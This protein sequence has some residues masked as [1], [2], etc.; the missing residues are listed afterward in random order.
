M[1]TSVNMRPQSIDEM[2]G[3]ESIREKAR[4]AVGAALNRDEPLGHCLLTSAGGGLGKTSFAQ[5]LA[6]E[7][8]AP[9]LATSGQCLV[10]PTDLRNMLIRIQPRTVLLCDEAHCLG[11]AACEELLIVLEEGV[12]NLNG[13]GS[14]IRVPLPP[15][16]FVAATTRPE[17]FCS[18]PLGQRFGLHFHFDFYTADEIGEIVANVFKRWQMRV[19][20]PVALEIAKRARG[21]PRIGIR[22]SERVRD[23]AQARQETTATLRSFKTAMDIEGIDDL[24]LTQAEQAILRRLGESHPRPVSART[25]STATGAQVATIHNF[26]Q[27]LVRFGLAEIGPGGRQI[28]E[29]GLRHLDGQGQSRAMR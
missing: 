7:M 1:T 2:I 25:L 26:E 22:L 4:V 10:G 9:F 20:A 5:I 23:V 8:Y 16:T 28:T 13:N 14:A 29:R 19:E 15:F 17:V 12:L 24:G 27:V 18:T 21:V 6:N 3:Q 11:R